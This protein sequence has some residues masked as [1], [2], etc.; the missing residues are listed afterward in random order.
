MH[1]EEKPRKELLKERQEILGHAEKTLKEEFIGIDEAIGSLISAVRSWYMCPEF[2]ERP[3]VVNLWGMTG[4]GKSALVERLMELL[5]M[6]QRYFSFDMGENGELRHDL[7]NLYETGNGEPFVLCLDEFQNA[8]TLDEWGREQ[9]RSRYRVIWELLDSGTFQDLNP[10]RKVFGLCEF[11]FDLKSMV[12]QGL[13]IEQGRVVARTDLFYDLTDGVHGSSNDQNE[14]PFFLSPH[15]EEDLFDLLRSRYEPP[16]LAE[17]LNSLDTQ[18]ALRL[19]EEAI[20]L[21]RAPRTVDCS[22]ALVFVI[23][24]LDEAYRVGDDHDPDIEADELHRRSLRIRVPD[25]KKALRKRFRSEQVARLGN[26]HIIYPALDQAS[27]QRIIEKELDRVSGKLRNIYGVDVVFDGKV[28]HMLYEEGVYPWQ[29]TRPVFTTVREKIDGQLGDVAVHLELMDASPTEILITMEDRELIVHFRREDRFL[30]ELRFPVRREL[31]EL[32]KNRKDDQQALTAAHEAGHAMLGILLQGEVPLAVLSNTAG[33]D[34]GGYTSFPRSE[35]C[36]TK[37][38]YEEKGAV[39]LGGI[40]AEELLF[41]EEQVTPSARFDIEQ[42]TE[43]A[44][45]ILKK[46][47]MG[48]TPTN[49]SFNPFMDSDLSDLDPGYYWN[50]QAEKKLRCWKDR[51]EAQ[52]RAHWGLF[53]KLAEKLSDQRKME[54]EELL[55]FLKAEA[56]GIFETCSRKKAVYPF[57]KALKE[58]ALALG[59]GKLV[60]NGDG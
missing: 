17:L 44:L 23:G 57:R 16:Q 43:L 59:N 19:L 9:D 31:R 34:A 5:D 25:I 37:K 30:D 26:Q 3:M 14:G 49:I 35:D 60:V 8:R 1:Q 50:E 55:E 42:A 46:W 24:N 10:G 54:Q 36:L 41:G 52:L 15:K 48:G 39:L 29:G 12:K 45:H 6:K 13:R 27:F 56:P 28:H 7:E 4:V 22:K 53:V 18:G 32:R 11:F 21:G 20:E 33:P 58:Q 40:A 51:A 47:G 2:Q 38:E